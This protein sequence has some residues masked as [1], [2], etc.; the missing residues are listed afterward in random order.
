MYSFQKTYQLSCDESYQKLRILLA[1]FA[2]ATFNIPVF[3]YF[4]KTFL[5]FR[6]I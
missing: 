5:R 6:L 4:F 3:Y 1:N 2:T